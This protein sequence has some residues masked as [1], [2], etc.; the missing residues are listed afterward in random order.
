MSQ[1]RFHVCTSRDRLGV[2]FLL[3]IEQ[4]FNQLLFAGVEGEKPA[5]ADEQELLARVKGLL[6]CPESLSEHVSMLPSILSR[7]IN[8][9]DNPEIDFIEVVTDLCEE[10]DVAREILA[11]ANS[12]MYRSK[13]RREI[14]SINQA[15]SLIGLVSIAYIASTVMMSH[16]TRTKSSYFQNFSTLIQKHALQT[17]MACRDMAH[18]HK[19]N[20]FSCHLLGL[21]NVVGIV[22][23]FNCLSGEIGASFDVKHPSAQL[24]QQVCQRWSNELTIEIVK[25]WS[26]PSAMVQAV[27]QFTEGN[28]DK[29]EE[30]AEM[31]RLADLISKV[32][33]LYSN[34]KLEQNQAV[35]LLAENGIPSD[36]AESFLIVAQEL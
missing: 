31:L 20:P 21:V 10:P 15:T 7:L 5:G 17:A 24:Y 19:I 22:Y 14:T 4:D 16:A 28:V 12:D 29:M 34:G 36:Y 18:Q 30:L 33:I 6:Y 13:G 3:S 35:E 11:I 9:I 23:C 27:E 26:L 8:T 25:E 1:L 2:S 32:S